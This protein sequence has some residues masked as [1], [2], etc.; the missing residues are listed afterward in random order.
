[1]FQRTLVFALALALVAI[2]GTARVSAQTETVKAADGTCA[3]ADAED[4][5]VVRVIDGE[6]L[7]LEG[8]S[9]LRLVGALAPRAFDVAGETSEWPL[10]EQAHLTLE[11]LATGRGIR[12]AFA[13]RR[14]DRYGRTLGHA[15]LTG[16]DGTW[17]QGEMLK[18]GLARAYALEGSTG[19]L[20]ELIAHETVAREAAIGLWAEPIYAVRSSDDTRALLRV[21]GTYQIVEGRVHAVSEVRGALFINFGEDWRQDFTAVLRAGPRK[22]AKASDALGATSEL[23]GR[24]VRVRGWIERRGGPMIE[25]PHAT[26]IEVLAAVESDS[27]SQASRAGTPSRRRARAKRPADSEAGAVE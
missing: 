13:G 4:R 9:E 26:A 22:Q 21:A 12:V 19:C 18:R 8:G 7:M 25:V 17:L 2:A 6:T 15:F 24:R 10:A 20:A 5:T 16:S 27:V 1:M 23:T 3:L 11:R 14:Q